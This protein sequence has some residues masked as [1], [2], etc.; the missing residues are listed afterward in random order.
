M[1]IGRS[2][3]LSGPGLTRELRELHSAVSEVSSVPFWDDQNVSPP[4]AE[5]IERIMSCFSFSNN[6]L[7][8]F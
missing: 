5:E 8:K 6:V 3:N 2:L 1:T 4:F 7:L